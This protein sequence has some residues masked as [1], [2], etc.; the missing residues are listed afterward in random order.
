M[1]ASVDAKEQ[2]FID[3]DGVRFCEPSPEDEKKPKT[4]NEG[5]I[6]YHVY[7]TETRSKIEE[8]SEYFFREWKKDDC[9]LYASYILIDVNGREFYSNKFIDRVINNLPK[10]DNIQLHVRTGKARRF[11]SRT[12]GESVEYIRP[13][14]TVEEVP[15][16]NS[17]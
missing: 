7:D 17:N 1:T 10:Q 14:V 13:V 16:Q 2:G 6:L 3:C 12:T 4:K 9:S 11:I 8:N 15:C 5:K